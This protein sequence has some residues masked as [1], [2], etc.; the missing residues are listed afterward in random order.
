MTLTELL[1]LAMLF[2][3][4]YCG[5]SAL[6]GP[7]RV[8]RTLA[9]AFP[10]GCCFW[11]VCVFLIAA[12]PIPSKDVFGMNLSASLLL[13]AGIAVVSLLF[14]ARQGDTLL[15]F[16]LPALPALVVLLFLYWLFFWAN[17]SIITADSL[18]H[19]HPQRGFESM[20][21]GRA[22][23]QTLA[24]LASLAGQDRYFFPFHPLFFV[25]LVVLMGECI[26]HEITSA[27]TTPGLALSFAF[28]GPILLA[29]THMAS[30]QMF[31]VNNHM[32]V[33][34]MICLAL[35]LLLG[36]NNQSQCVEVPWP[37]AAL[38]VIAVTPLSLLRLE[39]QFVGI[40]LL[41][42]MLGRVGVDRLVRVRALLL[43]LLLTAPVL[44]YLIAISID[45]G[46]TDA[47]HLG[48][49]LLATVLLPLFFYPQKPAFLGHLQDN[50]GKYALLCLILVVSAFLYLRLDKMVYRL[51]W[52]IHNAFDVS[53]WGF[54]PQVLI[55]TI[56]VLLVVRAMS[57][58]ATMPA[59]LGRIDSLLIFSIAAL[60]SIVF[61]TYFHGARLGWSSSQN[62][63]L[64]HFF[65][66][67][68]LW[69]TIQAG[70]GFARPAAAL[71][72]Q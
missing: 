38:A 42:V 51:G 3:V 39:G 29:S 65:P 47:M 59:N 52:V 33:A 14:I 62:R 53:H 5:T 2:G 40:I 67:I 57:G 32:L 64:F 56:F 63:M 43:Y 61:L 55:F 23:N 24:A 28:A 46:K 71:H 13:F 12:L 21:S 41:V 44:L 17:I 69:V 58:Y 68:I 50:A 49:M 22:F 25:S 10:M 37:L 9:G 70:I 30:I 15:R 26:Y 8:L 7:E 19:I 31:Y 1:L 4:G 72:T 66:A 11:A 16:L 18:S 54:A 45:G 27:G 20:K 35:S 60:L 6:A 34:T 36:K 48:V